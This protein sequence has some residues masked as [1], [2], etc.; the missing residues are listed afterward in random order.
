MALAVT[1]SPTLGA[2]VVARLGEELA[3]WLVLVG[4]V[5]RGIAREQGLELGALA[6]PAIGEPRVEPRV[7]VVLRAEV[8][9]RAREQRAASGV[10][11]AER[12]EEL[13][14][15]TGF[16]RSKTQNLVAM[17]R[18]RLAAPLALAPT[19]EPSPAHPHAPPPHSHP[20]PPRPVTGA[21]R[22]GR[23]R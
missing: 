10:V 5:G 12:V 1:A 22:A 19:V 2:S 4:R 3:R 15:S 23:P 8:V 16:F 7:G 14:R 18:A 6:L 21:A 9:P 17:A 20:H 11:H 13:I